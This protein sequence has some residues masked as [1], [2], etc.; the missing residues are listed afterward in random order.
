LGRRGAPSG[1]GAPDA[2]RRRSAVDSQ[3][4]ECQYLRSMAKQS[5]R[6]E[7]DDEIEPILRRWPYVPEHVKKTIVEVVSNYGPPTAKQHFPT[8]AGAKWSDVEIVLTSET[9]AE[10]KIGAVCQR[11]TFAAVGLADKRDGKRP[12]REWRMLRTYAENPEPDAYYK[13]PKRGNLKADISL[14]RQ[15]LKRFFGIPGDPLKPFKSALW[16]PRF[17]IRVDADY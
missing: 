17:K 6:K 14:F 5:A 12:L 8:P 16:L 10:F 11:Y 4:G 13:L 3:C 2:R 15:W 7:W 1:E 9:E